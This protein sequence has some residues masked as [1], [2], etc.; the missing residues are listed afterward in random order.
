MN[1]PQLQADGLIKN[2]GSTVALAGVSLSIAAGESVAIMGASGSGKTTLLHVLAGIVA[3]DAG[4]VRLA[5]DVGV[6]TVSELNES[7]RS[8]LRRT[9]FGFV[10]QQGL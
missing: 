10:F 6:V 5:T 8:A 1:T 7:A 9:A 4:S 3:P 2:Y